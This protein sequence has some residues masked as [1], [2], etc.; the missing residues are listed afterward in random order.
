[1]K[2]RV[3]QPSRDV[4]RFGKRKAPWHIEWRDPHT[5]QKFSKR[6]GPKKLADQSAADKLA[7]LARSEFGG[8]VRKPWADF[9]EQ[10]QR[11]YA[12]RM[13]SERS[14]EESK[15][16]LERFGKMM[17]PKMVDSVTPAMLDK[18]VAERLAE[19]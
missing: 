2:V 4:K 17:K 12:S 1:M 9:V 8:I 6:V 15:R 7:E 18:Y 19:R 13:R 10:Y 11:D 3:F 14:R 5:G 16:V